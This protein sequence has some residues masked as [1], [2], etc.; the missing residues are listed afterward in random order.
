MRIHFGVL[1]VCIKA[2]MKISADMVSPA[3]GRQFFPT[4]LKQNA[5][6]VADSAETCIQATS[7]LMGSALLWFKAILEALDFAATLSDICVFTRRADV[8]LQIVTIYVDDVLVCASNDDEIPDVFEYT[9]RR[10]RLND[11]GPITKLLGMEIDRDESNK[12]MY[13]TQ[14]T[15]IERKAIKYGM[16]K[17][18]RVD[19]PIPAGTSMVDNAGL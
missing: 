3:L 4:N 16:E 9:Q 8:R 10:I 13:V 12:S 17:S 15:Y 18:K 5:G 7:T 2:S 6:A 19:T 11:L 1:E 14:R